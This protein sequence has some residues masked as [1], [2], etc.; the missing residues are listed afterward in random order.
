MSQQFWPATWHPRHARLGFFSEPSLSWRE[1]G[2]PHMHLTSLPSRLRPLMARGQP[3]S[4]NRPSD[5]KSNTIPVVQRWRWN[6]NTIQSKGD[7]GMQL[8]KYH[9]YFFN[10]I[11][12]IY[13]ISLSDR[14]V[15]FLGINGKR[16]A[17]CQCFDGHSKT[18]TKCL[19]HGSPT[20]DLTSPV[21]LGLAYVLLVETNPFPNLSLFYRT[22][23]FEYPSVLSRFCFVFSP[24]ANLCAV[25]NMADTSSNVT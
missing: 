3:G 25:T 11:S 23:L 19:W 24:P 9:I 2:R 21:P 12:I 6:G 16:V 4:N 5:H 18:P 14:G 15:W 10:D 17:P 7:P 22:M 1:S 8:L 20:M 13:K